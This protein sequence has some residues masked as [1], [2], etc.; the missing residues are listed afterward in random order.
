MIEVLE[1]LQEKLRR[2]LLQLEA[3]NWEIE[4]ILHLHGQKCCNLVT[5]EKPVDE[6]AADEFI[7][8]YLNQE[9]WI[10][11][12]PY[13]D[14]AEKLYNESLAYF[15]SKNYNS[16]KRFFLFVIKPKLWL[17]GKA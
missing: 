14:Y 17:Q 16:A 12:I 10:T 9:A 4:H 15:N 8:A 1:S 11:S 5:M 2:Q 7:Q 6:T 3:E 13:F